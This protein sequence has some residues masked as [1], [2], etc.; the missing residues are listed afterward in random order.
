MTDW[1]FPGDDKVRRAFILNVL[2]A[3]RQQGLTFQEF[4][5]RV[6]QAAEVLD[7][8]AHERAFGRVVKKLRLDRNLPRKRLAESA[9]IPVRVLTQVELGHGGHLI[10]VPEVCRIAAGLKLQPHE[11]LEYYQDAIETASTIQRGPRP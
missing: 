2:T 3:I 11:L 10:S 9:G 7:R 6:T 5:R 1:K 8:R 4:E